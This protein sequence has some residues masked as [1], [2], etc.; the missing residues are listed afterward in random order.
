MRFRTIN[1][2][3]SFAWGASLPRE[4]RRHCARPQEGLIRSFPKIFELK[5]SG[6]NSCAMSNRKMWTNISS[7]NV[8]ENEKNE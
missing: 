4:D 8:K 2:R 1:R 6:A 3:W 7:Y 5:M